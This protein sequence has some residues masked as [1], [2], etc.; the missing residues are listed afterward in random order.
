MRK[1]LT[2]SSDPALAKLAADKELSDGKFIDAWWDE[3]KSR[4]ASLPPET[5]GWA[6]ASRDA[7][8]FTVNAKSMMP[9]LQ[10]VTVLGQQDLLDLVNKLYHMPKEVLKDGL[11]NRGTRVAAVD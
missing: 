5:P 9:E 8:E 10:G 6:T 4:E 1:A 2:K 7:D 11:F 3:M